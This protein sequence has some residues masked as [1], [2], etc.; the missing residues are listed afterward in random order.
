M[1]KI[2]HR[3]PVAAMNLVKEAYKKADP[4][5]DFNGSFIDENVGRWY[6]KEKNFSKI[7][8]IA[9]SVATLLSCLGL[10]A[11]SALMI[12]QRIKEIGVRKVLG[13]S[14]QNIATLLSKDFLL[15]VVLAIV[16]AAP[17]SWWLMNKWLSDFP[18]R[19]EISWWLFAVT[20]VISLAIAIITISVHTV[21]AAIA[22][23]VKSLRSE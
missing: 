8:G 4:G 10:F 12:G 18:Y 22:N 17:L 7:L 6:S 14:V 21:R 3:N 11:M 23:P 19:I 20:G 2:A 15:L 9:T 13:A 16:I 5:A 1:I